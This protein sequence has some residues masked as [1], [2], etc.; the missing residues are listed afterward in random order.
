MNESC[1]FVHQIKMLPPKQHVL[2]I[3]R[4]VPGSKVV[5]CSPS[6]A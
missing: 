4:D 2:V 3:V 6:L 1:T 5:G